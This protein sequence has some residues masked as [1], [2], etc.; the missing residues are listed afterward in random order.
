MAVCRQ[1]AIGV[2]KIDLVSSFLTKT[3]S[4]RLAE[5]AYAAQKDKPNLYINFA[6]N[7]T[8]GCDCEGHA[9]KI[10]MPDVG[11]FAGTDP[12]ALDQACLDVIERAMGRKYFRRGRHALSYGSALGLGSMAYELVNVV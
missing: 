7:I 10:I 11:I 8:R 3:F 9:M 6:C 1:G 5:Y 12:I 2:N 4:E